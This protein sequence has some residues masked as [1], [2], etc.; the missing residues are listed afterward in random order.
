MT[1]MTIPPLLGVSY[2]VILFYISNRHPVGQVD[3]IPP[4]DFVGTFLWNPPPRSVFFSI[5]N[6]AIYDPHKSGAFHLKN[7]KMVVIIRPWKRRI[8]PN[9]QRTKKILFR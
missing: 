3:P 9:I 4:I 1:F 6:V 7:L 5:K 2:G 8:P